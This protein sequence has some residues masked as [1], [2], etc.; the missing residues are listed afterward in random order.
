MGLTQGASASGGWEGILEP[1]ERVLWQGQPEPGLDLSRASLGRLAS[2]LPLVIFGLFWIAVTVEAGGDDLIARLFPLFGVMIL[3][4]GL[5][6]GGLRLLWDSYV[7]RHTVYTLTDRR[8]FIATDPM[9]RKRLKSWP[10]DEMVLLDYDGE[11]PG[12]I[13]FGQQFNPNRPGRRRVGFQRIAE[14]RRVYDMMRKIRAGGEI[15]RP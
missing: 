2:A 11:V 8:A 7:L 13:W 12:T 1:G 3:I 10:L 14:A 5:W 6:H 9:G 4:G 15:V